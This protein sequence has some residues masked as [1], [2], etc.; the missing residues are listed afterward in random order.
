ME[1][2]LYTLAALGVLFIIEN[3]LI[4]GVL[5][6]SR[7]KEKVDVERTKRIYEAGLRIELQKAV[8]NEDY[9]TASNLKKEIENLAK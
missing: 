9:E 6:S 2:L 4:I 1:I 5:F 7:K 3:T 8:D